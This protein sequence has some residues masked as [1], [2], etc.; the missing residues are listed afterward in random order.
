MSA[1]CYWP[2]GQ[3]NR[4][5]RATRR[6]KTGFRR[7]STRPCGRK[8]WTY[9]KGWT[10]RPLLCHTL[11]NTTTPSISQIFFH[12]NT[13]LDRCEALYKVGSA[14]TGLKAIG[15]HLDRMTCFRDDKVYMFS[16]MHMCHNC[17]TQLPW[18]VGIYKALR[19]CIP[20]ASQK[21]DRSHHACITL[22]RAYRARISLLSV[23][24]DCATCIALYCTCA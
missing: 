16:C 5:G 22:S 21:G 20:Y 24:H 2:F 23:C 14:A 15:Q 4:T 1:R 19:I 6:H 13:H 18:L 17:E 12:R 7:W 8:W 3:R 9:Q 11:N 10:F